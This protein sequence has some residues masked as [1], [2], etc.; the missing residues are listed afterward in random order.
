MQPILPPRILKSI[1]FPDECW[2]WTGYKNEF[3]YGRAYWH[4]KTRFVHRIVYSLLVSE[5][6]EGA[7]L[8]HLCNVRACCNPAH[9]RI[10]TNRD[11]ILRGT[12]PAAINARKTHCKHGHPLQGRNIIWSRRRNGQTVRVCRVCHYGRWNKLRGLETRPSTIRALLTE[13]GDE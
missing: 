11:N 1:A 12:C 3:G 7:V 4:G 2:T 6:P 10:T 5:I 9:L 13:P 8:D